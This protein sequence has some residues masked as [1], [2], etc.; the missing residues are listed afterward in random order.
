MAISIAGGRH[1]M[2]AQQ[3]GEETYLLDTEAL[4]RVIS[5]DPH[6][7]LVEAEAGIR[8]PE[9]LDELH[10]RQA[11]M[12]QP[13]GIRQKQTGAD[14]L[15]LGGALSANA[16]G[17]GLGCKPLIGDIEAFTLIDADGQ[18]RYC[19]RYRNPELFALAIGGYGLFGVIAT[20][21]LRLVPRQMVRRVVTIIDIDDLVP[22]I[23]HRIAHGFLYGDFQ[24][25][26]DPGSEQFLR[27]GVFS[28]YRPIDETVE[29]SAN[30]RQLHPDDW[31]RL[32]Y[33]AHTDK[34]RAF[35]EYSR[36]YLATDGQHYWS[37]THQLSEYLDDYHRQLDQWLG[38][39]G[40]GTE[41]ITE[42]YVP[43]E[44]VAPFLAKVRQDFRE[45]GANLIY[46]TIRFIE[47]DDE[48]FL[49]WAKQPYACI[50]FNLHTAHDEAAL[51][52]TAED[53]RLLIGRAIEH[54]GSYYLTYHRWASRSQVETCY[55]QFRTFLQLKRQ[56]DP[57]ERFQSEW[58]R[59]H[60]A[61]LA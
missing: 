16:H 22:S 4:N 36:Y 33:L 41:M 52:R 24:F 60:Q 5:F 56:Y 17:R 29:L 2:G 7:G 55:P 18:V 31:M 3:F 40:C 14:R 21:T 12:N 57:E 47:E 15:S 37:D 45:S 42:I 54:G 30:Q 26:I 46:G 61:L 39:D 38:P 53:F 34:Q 59:H 11:G 23:E 19:S 50:I 6:G 27:R 9:L 48:S 43:R 58:Y 8:W 35:D 44:T 25:A 20:V 10:R 1:A 49:A 13:W 28:C 32:F 51:R